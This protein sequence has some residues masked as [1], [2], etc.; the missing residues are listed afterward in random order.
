VLDPLPV[1]A[2]KGKRMAD[3]TVDEKE[4]SSKEFG[5]RK[6]ARGSN[7]RVRHSFDLI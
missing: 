4:G 1:I 3:G 5:A 7:G 2:D 6:M